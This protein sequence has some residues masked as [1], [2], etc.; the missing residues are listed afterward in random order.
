MEI[1]FDA[2]RAFENETGLGNYSRLIIDLV[3]EELERIYLFSSKD[4]P[5]V[6]WD[7]PDN[8]KTIHPDYKL[9]LWRTLGITHRISATKVDIYHGLSH[10]LPFNIQKAKVPTIVTMHDCIFHHFPNSY[11]W[12]DQKIYDRKW[13]NAVSKS[14]KIIAISKST[15]NDLIKFYDAPSKKVEIIHLF[16]K[17][18]FTADISKEVTDD[19]L[20]KYKLKTPYILFVGNHHPR[21]NLDLVIQ[22]YVRATK[23]IPP[24]VI[25]G[26]ERKLL[27]DFVKKHHLS[28]KIRIPEQQVSDEELAHLYNR[29]TALVYPS[30]YEGFGLPVLEAMQSGT[31]VITCHNSSLKEVGG[32]A[33]LYTAS[34]DP[35][36]LEQHIHSL[37][38]DPQL[39]NELEQKGLS[40]AKNFSRGKHKNQLIQLYKNLI[41]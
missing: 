26:G 6:A 21:K 12:I 24:V 8:A 40:Q 25:V 34:D 36:E 28:D 7:I 39:L 19:T 4:S 17:D 11:T 32:D 22:T 15:A 9:P 1:G 38:K 29:A 13:K 20:R 30:L 14:D 18:I 5:M 16:A 23:D 3:A 10:E 2:K 27:T 31:A 33:V 41:E 37:V 35:K